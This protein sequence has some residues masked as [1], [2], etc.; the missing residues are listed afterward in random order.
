MLKPGMVGRA[1][2]LRKNYKKSIIIPATALLHLQNSTAVMVVENGIA[3]QRV[4]EVSASNG[5]SVMV[6]KGLSAGDHLI[7][8]GAFQVS[9]GTKVIY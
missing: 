4:V 8:T 7:T 5:D 3:K 1:R 2:I 9:D 6:G